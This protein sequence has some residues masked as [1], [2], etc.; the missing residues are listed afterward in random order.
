MRKP[1]LNLGLF[2]LGATLLSSCQKVVPDIPSPFP[3]TVYSTGVTPQYNMRMF[4]GGIEVTDTAKIRKYFSTVPARLTSTSI[5]T[6]FPASYTFK[7]PDS[8]QFTNNLNTSYNYDATTGKHVIALTRFSAIDILKNTFDV[9]K[10]YLHVPTSVPFAGGFNFTE[11]IVGYGNYISFKIPVL[12]YKYHKPSS[13]FTATGLI[14]NEF[15]AT[16]LST[17]APTDTIAVQEFYLYYA[18]KSSY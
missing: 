7:G 18:A 8:L 3:I 15:N 12:N 2:L 1:Y 11:F 4:V 6:G 5:L 10:F 17:M 14:N 16:G 9:G 13:S